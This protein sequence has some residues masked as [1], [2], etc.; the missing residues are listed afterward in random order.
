M[1]AVPY[2]LLLAVIVCL[3]WA[4]VATVCGQ[5][6]GKVLRPQIVSFSCYLMAA[7]S[8]IAS[9]GVSSPPIFSTDQTHSLLSHHAPLG[10]GQAHVDLAQCSGGPAP[11]AMPHCI[12]S[13]FA[14]KSIAFLQTTPSV[15]ESIMSVDFCQ[16]VRRLLPL[17]ST[18]ILLRKPMLETA[19]TILFG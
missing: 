12:I 4:L 19:P 13:S 18:H 14:A 6:R 2:Y 17:I 15:S 8:A 1:A 11:L 5:L 9:E 16:L 10:Q 3:T 7:V